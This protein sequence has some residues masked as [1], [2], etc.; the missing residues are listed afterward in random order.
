MNNSFTSRT[1]FSFFIVT[2]FC[3]FA[4]VACRLIYL[5][6]INHEHAQNVVM[7]NRER[8]QEV[9]ALRG[10]ITDANG[11]LLASSRA[12]WNIGVDPQNVDVR[13]REKLGFLAMILNAD[14]S[15][16]SEKFGWNTQFTEGVSRKVRWRKLAGEVD[17]ST[18]NAVNRLDIQGVYGNKTYTRYYPA[19]H[20]G[21]HVVGFIN[22]N[23]QAVMG[24]EQSLDFYLKGS[25]GW[26]VREINGSRREIRE[27]RMRDFASEEGYD[28]Q[29]TLDL[30]IQQAVEEELD[31]VIL[32]LKP[33]SV[34][35][36]VSEVQSGRILAM[37]SR[38]TFNPNQFRDYAF[39]EFRNRAIS[40]VYEPGSTFKVITA[41]GFINDGL[42]DR[43]RVFD[44]RI[45]SA[46]HRNRKVVLPSDTRLYGELRL[47]DVIKKSS[48][49]GASLAGLELGDNRLFHYCQG[50]GF[51]ERTGVELKGEEKGILHDLARWDHYSAS[52]VSI[53]YNIGVTPLQMHTA[54]SVIANGGMR[55]APYL[56]DRL[57][58][59]NG[60]QVQFSQVSSERVISQNTAAEI[61]ECLISAASLEGTGKR[62]R[63]NNILIAGKT[64]TSRKLL[65]DGY[66]DQRH[67]GS[68][69]GFFPAYRPEI[70]ITIV[71]ND[72]QEG[73]STYGG[74]VAAP[75]FK[76]IAEKII[77]YRGIK[78]EWEARELV[79]QR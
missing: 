77:A 19:Q 50:F 41:S 45:S 74:S 79:A 76:H 69:S 67:V 21:A 71:V 24:V 11:N 39:E 43:N 48:N 15:E 17:E 37:S 34:V 54:M 5:H 25:R 59:A 73:T 51:G 58:N 66:N 8:F 1:R 49:R 38:P 70:I 65:P 23:D 32:E 52:R 4:V 75:S 60:E 27:N 44:C 16:L 62:A 30:V 13:D 3:L 10:Q 63:L 64:G 47:Q 35:A 46:F 6:V 68:F 2:V 78:P 53:G 72:P 55:V 36:L 33:S 61:L 7:Q 26:K 40:D 18:L 12:V 29:L 28:V 31:R 56:V 22:K 57:I 42:G 20:V 9:K 14:E